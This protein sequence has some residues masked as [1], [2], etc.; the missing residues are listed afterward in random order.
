MYLDQEADVLDLHAS[1]V[2]DD[3]PIKAFAMAVQLF[4][5]AS[6]ISW[7]GVELAYA[8]AWCRVP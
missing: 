6:L 3:K 8:V 1:A 2:H 7:N 5:D 4:S